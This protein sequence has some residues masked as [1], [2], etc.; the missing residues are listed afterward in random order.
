M[1][2]TDP[3]KR[4]TVLYPHSVAAKL[5]SLVPSPEP[6]SDCSTPMTDS[7]FGN[8][9][10]PVFIWYNPLLITALYLFIYTCLWIYITLEWNGWRESKFSKCGETKDS[11]F[12]FRLD[13]HPAAGKCEPVSSGARP[14][15]VPEAQD[16]FLITKGDAS[17]NVA[18]RPGWVSGKI[19][20]SIQRVA[21]ESPTSENYSL[22]DL[23]HCYYIKEASINVCFLLGQWST[24]K[25][26]DSIKY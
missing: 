23:L 12:L 25:I 16:V 7:P 10:S 4:K 5:K 13:S 14:E 24:Q 20:L 8:K 17:S 18:I 22:Q 15:A 3:W 2:V 19:I 1:P 9:I 11:L 21:K 26:K 6:W